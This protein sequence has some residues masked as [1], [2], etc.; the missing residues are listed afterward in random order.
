M[1]VFTL[2]G[3]GATLPLV[4]RRLKLPGRPGAGR[5][6]RGRG[7]A[8]GQRAAQE[9]LDELADSAPTRWWTGCAERWTDRTNLAWERLGGN[10]RETPSQAYGRLR[11][12]M[13][14]AEREFPGRPGRRADP[15]GGAGTGLS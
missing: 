13:I 3:Q 15:R 14:D 2:V 4:A 9:R 1:I 10:E 12:E 11:Q 8:A 7:A 6:V 5:A